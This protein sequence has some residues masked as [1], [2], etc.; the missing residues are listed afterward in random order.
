MSEPLAVNDAP[1]NLDEALLAS[2]ERF[3]NRELSWLAFNARVLE[4]AEPPARMA[5]GAGL[6]PAHQVALADDSEDAPPVVDDRQCAHPPFQELPRNVA[7][8]RL[9]GN[10]YDVDAH[11][12]IRAHRFLRLSIV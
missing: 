1:L 2:P 9:R 8:V 3:F 4:E 5:L 7:Y 11:D 6:P 12:L 10:R